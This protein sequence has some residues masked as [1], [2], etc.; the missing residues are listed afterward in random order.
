M[1]R[2]PPRSTRTDTPFPTRRSS[3]LVTVLRWTYVANA[4]ARALGATDLTV[5]PLMSILWYF[6][7][8]ANL[9][10]PLQGMR[11]IWK[12]SVKPPDWETVGT[13][14]PLIDRKRT[15]LNSSH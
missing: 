4:N 7:P 12:G 9:W 1:V 3:D 11:E 6:I 15:R 5:T 8:L 10:M 2:R 13:P 14:P